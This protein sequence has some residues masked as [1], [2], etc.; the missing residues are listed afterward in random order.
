MKTATAPIQIVALAALFVAHLAF[1][2]DFHGIRRAMRTISGV[3]ANQTVIVWDAGL[4]EAL[5]AG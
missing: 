4:S 3:S 1:A 2:H 5:P